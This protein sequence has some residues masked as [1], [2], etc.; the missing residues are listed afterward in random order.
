MNNAAS[1]RVEILDVVLCLVS[2]PFPVVS[3]ARSAVRVVLCLV[4]NDCMYRSTAFIKVWFTQM[5]SY[6]YPL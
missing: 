6:R 1:S 2:D 5:L 4:K 3:G